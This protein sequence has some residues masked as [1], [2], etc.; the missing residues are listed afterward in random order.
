MLLEAMLMMAADPAAI[1]CRDVSLTAAVADYASGMRAMDAARIAALFG[2]DGQAVIV[3]R[4]LT[5]SAEIAEMLRS[6][7]G[8]HV[9]TDTMTIATTIGLAEGWRTEGPYR[10]TGIA[11]DGKHYLSHGRFTIDWRCDSQAGWR[12]RR[13]ETRGD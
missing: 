5:G 7:A 1:R 3:N 12:V 4:T 10:Q 2:E 11:P 6:F 13:L 9:L 8:Y